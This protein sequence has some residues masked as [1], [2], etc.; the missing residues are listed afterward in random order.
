MSHVA[1]HYTFT[2]I[3]PHKSL[4]KSI[5]NQQVALVS[6]HLAINETLRFG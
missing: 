4:N 2:Q 3:D 1:L 5:D 6:Y